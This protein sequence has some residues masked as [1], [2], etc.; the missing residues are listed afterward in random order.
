[1]V[2][3]DIRRIGISPTR[4]T[5]LTNRAQ[6]PKFWSSNRKPVASFGDRMLENPYDATSAISRVEI[7]RRN[8]VWV[9]IVAAISSLVL[10]DASLYWGCTE[11]L[12]WRFPNHLPLSIK[13]WGI[14]SIAIL[15]FVAIALATN[16]KIGSRE[17]I[18]LIATIPSALAFGLLCAIGH[19]SIFY[20]T[21]VG[22]ALLLVQIVALFYYRRLSE[23][24]GA[25]LLTFGC[26]G[27]IVLFHFHMLVMSRTQ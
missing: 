4:I 17:P 7:D 2:E 25:F 8:S 24:W 6:Q 3:R 13:L 1:M 22:C 19:R 15:V 16:M 23:T 26:V 20:V 11:W 18:L 9:T 5:G 21:E 14:G 10:N 12:Y 27:G